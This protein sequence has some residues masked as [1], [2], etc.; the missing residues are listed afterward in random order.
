M[1]DPDFKV[2]P[3][4]KG[5]GVLTA[6][7]SEKTTRGCA[8]L[9]NELSRIYERAIFPTGHSGAFDFNTVSIW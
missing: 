4:V 3:G 5:C 7:L 6:N 2:D 1:D 8:D 9:G